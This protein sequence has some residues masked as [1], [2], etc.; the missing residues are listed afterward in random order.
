MLHGLHVVVMT[1][2]P[3][4]RE[5]RRHALVPTV[6][7]DEVDV[8]VDEQVALGCTPVDLDVLALVGV[9]EVHE[10]RGVLRVV[11]QQQAVGLERVEDPSSERV[12]QLVVVHA[13]VQ[14]ERGD[15]HDVVDR[16]FGREVEHGLDDAL[17]YVGRAHGGKRQ[18]DVVERDRQLH[19]REEQG[20]QRL[21][22]PERVEERVPDGVVGVLDRLQ[23]LRRVDDPRPD[24]QLLEAEALPVEE[25]RRRGRAVDLEDE[26]GPA[27]QRFL[28]RSWR[29]SNATLT[30]P[31]RPAAVA[32]SMASLKRSSG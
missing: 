20:R 8:D 5:T 31:L 1:Q 15:Q 21:A 10:V 32:W 2:R 18:R 11:L 29:R 7:G 16:G 30:A 25:Q 28:S 9:A 19:A 24:R 13:S 17:A 4:G 23:G 12:P 22:V 3:V 27:H 26:P 6:H 14:G